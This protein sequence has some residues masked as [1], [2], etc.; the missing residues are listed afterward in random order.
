[1]LRPLSLGEIFDR[2]VTVYVRNFALFSL[3]ALVVVL[4]T[5]TMQFIIG[6]HQATFAQLLDQVQHPGK[7][8]VPPAGGTQTMLLFAFVA[9]SVALYSFMLVAV[10]GAIGDLYRGTRPEWTAC[11]ARASRRIG[12]IAVALLGEIA[13]F[14]GLLVGG[15]FALVVVFFVAFLLV[16]VSLALG[17]VAMIFSALVALAWFV[18]LMLAYLAFGLAFNAIANEAVSAPGALVRGFSRVFNRSEL[19]RATLICLALTAINL[20]LSAVSLSVAAVFETLHMHLLNVAVTAGLSLVS[21][22]F[23]CVLLTVYYFDVRVRREGL[24]LQAQ[25][26]ELQPAPTAP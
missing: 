11:Y 15:A 12:G 3:I 22:A 7:A 14:C 6:L 1:M 16:R 23:V 24:D 20:G 8:P 17:V 5:A 10:A 26:D 13:A 19:G 18:S 21:S 2:A 25:I 4:P 9:V